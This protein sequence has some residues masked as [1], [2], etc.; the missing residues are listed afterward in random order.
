MPYSVMRGHSE[1]TKKSSIPASSCAAWGNTTSGPA[2]TNLSNT[3]G[4]GD[5]TPGGLPTLLLVADPTFWARV[6]GSCAQ[7]LFTLRGPVGWGSRGLS[8][9]RALCITN[10]PY[11]DMLLG[12]RLGEFEKPRGNLWGQIVEILN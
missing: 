4:L 1:S 11:R 10:R 9:I 6:S 7:G 5:T 2:R 3:T 8:S 12:V